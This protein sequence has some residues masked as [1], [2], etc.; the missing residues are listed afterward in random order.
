MRFT[1]AWAETIAQNAT[2]KIVALCLSTCCL[3]L[4]IMT[5]KLAMKE[6]LIIER[7][8]YSRVLSPVSDDRSQTEVEAFVKEALRQRFDSDAAVVPGFLSQEEEGA[9]RQE[10]ENFRARSISQKVILHAPPKIE[11]DHV[12]VETDRLLSVAEVR[13]AFVF[14][15]NLTLMPVE[16]TEANPYGLRLEQVSAPRDEKDT[17]GTDKK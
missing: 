8:C 6:P 9:R 3:V 15:L 12:S 7:A 4:A 11:G 1:T 2:Y 16:R 10:Q 13:S 17:K 5:V 14:P